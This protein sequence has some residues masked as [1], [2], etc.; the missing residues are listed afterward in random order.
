MRPVRAAAASCFAL[1]AAPAIQACRGNPAAVCLQMLLYGF[2]LVKLAGI[3]EPERSTWLFSW[4]GL[5][6]QLTMLT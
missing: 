1:D 3:L 6:E 2:V 4:Y 5:C